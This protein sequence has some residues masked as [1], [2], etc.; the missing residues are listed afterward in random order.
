MRMQIPSIVAIQIRIEQTNDFP[1][2]FLLLLSLLARTGSC[3]GNCISLNFTADAA[4]FR[5]L[6]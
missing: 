4:T 6:T 5:P 1:S 2:R 3:I